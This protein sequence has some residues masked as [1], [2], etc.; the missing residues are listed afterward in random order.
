MLKY[1]AALELFLESH[2]QDG[3]EP[4]LPRAS[5]PQRRVAG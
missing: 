5:V 4:P 1:P 3:E 2:L